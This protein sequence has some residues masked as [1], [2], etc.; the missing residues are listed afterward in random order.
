MSSVSPLDYSGSEVRKDVRK[1][2]IYRERC[3]GWKSK[4]LARDILQ[5]LSCMCCIWTTA[6]H[7]A[8]QRL[9]SAQQPTG[10]A[11][12]ANPTRRTVTRENFTFFFSLSPGLLFSE[13]GPFAKDFYPLPFSNI[14]EAHVRLQTTGRLLRTLACCV[15]VVWWRC[16]RLQQQLSARWRLF[17]K[18][19]LE[20]TEN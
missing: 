20:Q 13:G 15:A 14:L 17:N 2:Y 4:I 12:T 3:L 1:I 9:I 11:H 8:A 5:R 16:H 18:R 6:G 10:D 19:E 7:A